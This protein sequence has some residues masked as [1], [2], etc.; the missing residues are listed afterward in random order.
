MISNSSSNISN[1][2]NIS[3]NN[4]IVVVFATVRGADPWILVDVEG[5]SIF[6]NHC[7]VLLQDHDGE[8]TEQHEWLPSSRQ[9]RYS[10][11]FLFG[12]LDIPR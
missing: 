9:Q 11:C 7:S 6:G 8:K 3:N 10:R 12:A 4:S 1:I 2:S 5:M